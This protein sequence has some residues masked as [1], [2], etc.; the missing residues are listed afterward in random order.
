VRGISDVLNNKE[1][2]D[3]A[4]SQTTA[5]GNAS[6]F[7]F[8]V[9]AKYSRVSSQ[10]KSNPSEALPSGTLAIM[11]GIRTPASFVF[12]ESPTISALLEPVKLGD[13]DAAADA[14]LSVIAVT[15][16]DGDNSL[17]EALLRY[18]N[19][20]T[21]DLKWAALQTVECVA[22]LLPVLIDRALLSYLA[23][24]QNFSV[25]ASA[26]TICMTLADFAPA[27]VP[28]DIVIRLSKHD[29]DWYVQAPANAAIKTLARSMPNII[30]LYVSR[31]E[32][33]DRWEREHSAHALTDIAEQEPDLIDRDVLRE[34]LKSLRSLGDKKCARQIETVL[35]LTKGSSR[36]TQ[37]KYGL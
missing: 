32:S 25:R 18:Y 29:E 21:E 26:S 12:E 9:L 6:A 20:P 34:K 15:R 1:E 19:C 31:L 30:R 14:A 37:F 16:P 8:E 27:A 2:R 23:C 5:A 4:G 7:A 11:P 28:T 13:W 3:A 10:N 36:S 35:R 22:G 24:H 17:F 33:G